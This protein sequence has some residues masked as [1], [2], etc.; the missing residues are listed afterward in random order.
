MDEKIK[1]EKR[2]WQKPELIVL[3]RSKPEEAVLS[4]CKSSGHGGSP[5]VTP[6]YDQVGCWSPFNAC[7]LCSGESIT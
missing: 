3:V 7:A 4:G 5:G 1:T 2:P 6:Y